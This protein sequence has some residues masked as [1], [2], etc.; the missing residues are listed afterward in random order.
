MSRLVLLLIEDTVRKLS[1][2]GRNEEI[3]KVEESSLRSNE[4]WLGRAPKNLFR[5]LS[6]NILHFHLCGS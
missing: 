4:L 2:I 1:F 3:T 5:I 6:H